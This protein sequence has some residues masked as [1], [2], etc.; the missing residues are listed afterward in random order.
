MKR[1]IGAGVGVVAALAALAAVVLLY[2]SH[3]RERILEAGRDAP[4]VAPSRVESADNAVLVAIDSTAAGRIGLET[5]PL[6]ASSGAQEV[7]LTGEV[8]AEPERRAAIRS[9]V[10]GRLSVARGARWPRLGDRVAAGTS[11]AQVSDALPIAAPISGT[12]TRVGAQPGAIVEAGQELL[13]IVDQSRPLVRIV[14]AEGAA[15][16]PHS[17]IVLEP[18][19]GEGRITGRLVGPSLEADPATRRATYLYRADR[20]WPGSA[21]G[22]PVEAT[23]AAAATTQGAMHKGVFVPD[24]AVVQWDG[25]AWTYV[26]RAPDRFERVRVPTDQPATGG[27]IVPTGLEVGDTVVVTGAQELLSEEF[28]ARV[29]VGDESGE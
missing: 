22:T 3:R 23:V 5:A 11:L 4:V 19:S 10:A 6:V 12:V 20:A 18:V 14:S 2:L 29:T 15:T 7:R 24:R 28:R 26:R 25:L 21:P 13:E 1:G 9:P 16:R 17:T 8:V 27:W